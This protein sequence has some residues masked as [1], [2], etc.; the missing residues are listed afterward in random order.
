MTTGEGHSSEHRSDDAPVPRGGIDALARVMALLF[1]IL[2]VRAI[3]MQTARANQALQSVVRDASPRRSVR[4]VRGRLLDVHGAVLAQDVPAFRIEV[5]ARARERAPHLLSVLEATLHW[6]PA[7]RHDAEALLAS[8][9]VRD[10]RLHTLE[11]AA[12]TDDLH[13]LERALGAIVGV[14]VSATSTREYPLGAEMFHVVG[15]SR[16]PS[17]IERVLDATLRGTPGWERPTPRGQDG[18]HDTATWGAL[19]SAAGERRANAPIDGRT[20]RLTLDAA[21]QHDIARAFDD[22]GFTTGAAV[23]L[24]ASTGRLLAAYSRPSLDPAAFGTTLSPIDWSR[25]RDAPSSPLVDQYAARA[26]RP[27]FTYVPFSAMAAFDTNDGADVEPLDCEG[28]MLI[29]HRHWHDGGTHGHRVDL[30]RALTSHCYLY[31]FEMAMSTSLDSHVAIARAFGLGAPTG[32]LASPESR[33]FVRDYNDVT[34]RERRFRLDF[35]LTGAI[36][37]DESV[38]PMQLAVAYAALVNG[39]DVF[40][41]HYVD[42]VEATHGE[43][44]ALPLAIPRRR[45]EVPH[46]A[47]EHL[48]SALRDASSSFGEDLAGLD[49]HP[50]A[51]RGRSGEILN[52]WF[53]GFFPREAPRYVVVVFVAAVPNLGNP[54]RAVALSVSHHLRTAAGGAQ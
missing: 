13:R 49:S 6:T 53:A 20:V 11:S 10:L 7:R 43:L 16:G 29:G 8:L 37:V 27:G 34:R 50:A 32:F 3:S 30:V 24:E 14:H 21:L 51:G 26:H 36:G 39:G 48:V 5:D 15:V 46:G 40:E 47:R 52:N 9:D 45:V 25:W 19:L 33:G 42:A 2:A 18:S 54:A 1:A 4:A 38:T 22:T 35:A 12:R 23:V 41:P 44:V 17:G 31:C 28:S